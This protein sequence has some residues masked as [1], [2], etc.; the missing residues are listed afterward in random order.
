MHQS[1]QRMGMSITR[2]LLTL[3][4]QRLQKRAEFRR[5]ALGGVLMQDV[6]AFQFEEN[7][8]RTA[9]RH[10]FHLFSRGHAAVGPAGRQS[11]ATGGKPLLPIL[12]LQPLLRSHHVFGIKGEPPAVVAFLERV[13]KIRQQAWTDTHSQSAPGRKSSGPG[14]DEPDIRIDLHRDV[15]NDQGSHEIGMLRRELQSI[16]AAKRVAKENDWSIT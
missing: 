15:F 16:D 2:R 1:K 12:T 9:T 10:L 11:W 7:R 6:S 5:E 13:L 8:V 3:G 4:L 14:A